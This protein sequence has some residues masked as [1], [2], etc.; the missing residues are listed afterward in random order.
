MTEPVRID[1]AEYGWEDD[2]PNPEAR[3]LRD[4]IRQTHDAEHEG[5]AR[6]CS[7]PLCAGAR[8]V[9]VAWSEF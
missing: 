6:W 7:H 8:E 1:P 4:L 5:A 9:T 3:R 2:Y